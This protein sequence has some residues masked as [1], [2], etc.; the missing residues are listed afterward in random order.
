M[1]PSKK[2]IVFKTANYTRNMLQRTIL[3][4]TMLL[5]AT[6]IG[7]EQEDDNYIEFNDR[8]NV[9]HGVY[10][11]LTTH[12]GEIDGKD[13]YIGGLKVA[14]VAN[15]KFEVG[16]VGNFLYSEQDNPR[17]VNED[18]IAVYGGLHLEPIL[19]SENLVNL[20][21][22]ILIGA[23]GVGYFGNNFDDP[24]DD[25]IDE[26]EI[27]AIFVLEPGMSLLFNVSRYVQLEAGVK[28]R[29]S[30]KLDLDLNPLDRIN[31]FSGG[32]GVKI[33][34]FN[35]GRNRYKKHLDNEQ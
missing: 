31:G 12:F 18:L 16:F 24:I 25:N 6:G 7:Q 3:I 8:K 10:L 1:Q 17:T 4:T 27:D 34:V 15:R 30:N 9:V 19:F 20:S 22:P 23:G 35:M 33:G 11:G 2:S 21:F 14:Y 26:D 13:T 5:G 28:Y 29:F 32:I